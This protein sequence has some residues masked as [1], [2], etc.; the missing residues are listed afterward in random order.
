MIGNGDP[1]FFVSGA[2]RGS[3]SGWLAIIVKNLEACPGV[4]VVLV[5]QHLL[6]GKLQDF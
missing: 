2:I 6:P 4:N 5:E 1:T 3:K